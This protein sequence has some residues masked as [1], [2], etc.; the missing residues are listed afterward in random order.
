ME[1][2][3]WL[4]PEW[5]GR[6]KELIHL[7]GAAELIGVTRSAVSNWA[8]RYSDFPGIVMLTGVAPRRQKFVVREEFLTFAARRQSGKNRSRRKPAPR[9]PRTVIETARIAHWEAQI[10]RLT[11]LESKYTAAVTRTRAA[12]KGAEEKLQAARDSLAAEIN[13]V[14]QIISKAP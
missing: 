9:R 7:A 3:T 2:V 5:Q 12:R 11:T 14:Q 4:R 13:A 10:E 6:E 1:S 8:Q